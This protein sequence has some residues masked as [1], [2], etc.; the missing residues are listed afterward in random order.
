MTPASK[1][2]LY[3]AVGREMNEKLS[4]CLAALKL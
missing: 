4:L 3:N 1:T 2:F